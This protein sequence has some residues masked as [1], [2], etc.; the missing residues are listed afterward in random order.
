MISHSSTLGMVTVGMPRSYYADASKY[1]GVAALLSLSVVVE[2]IVSKILFNIK[3]ETMRL[4][5][6]EWGWWSIQLVT[7]QG[8]CGLP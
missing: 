7:G 6:K 4:I 8:S 5:L 3:I 2:Q 1:H